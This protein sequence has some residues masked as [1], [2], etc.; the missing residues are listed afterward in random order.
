M[1]LYGLHSW[2]VTNKYEWISKSGNAGKSETCTGNIFQSREQDSSSKKSKTGPGQEL[3]QTTAGRMDTTS[4]RYIF[5]PATLNTHIPVPNWEPTIELGSVLGIHQEANW[6]VPANLIRQI[7]KQMKEFESAS[8]IKDRKPKSIQGDQAPNAI[9]MSSTS[10][11]N[12]E[13]QSLDRV[14]QIHNI[15]IIF[16]LLLIYLFNLSS[17]GHH[18]PMSRH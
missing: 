10:W 4:T 17:T 12:Y 14:Y 15:I 16:R 11:R 7:Q 2:S 13:Q 3:E 8:I 5:L 1:W 6:H 18:W 9:I